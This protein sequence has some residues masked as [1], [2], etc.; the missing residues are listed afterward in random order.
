MKLDSKWKIALCLAAVFLAGAV[1]GGLVSLKVAKNAVLELAKADN[2]EALAMKHLD[3]KLHLTLEQEKQIRP[4]VA[5]LMDSL[6]VSRL[7]LI[8]QLNQ[9]LL[10]ARQQIEP[11]LDEPQKEVLVQMAAKRRERMQRLVPDLPAE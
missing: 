2:W 7:A 6:R 3:R 11:V 4:V 9:D 5:D 10:A 8:Q 1:T